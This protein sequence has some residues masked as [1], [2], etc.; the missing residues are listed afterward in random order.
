M[1]TAG[2]VELGQRFSALEQGPPSQGVPAPMHSRTQVPVPLQVARSPVVLPQSVPAMVP[3][4]MQDPMNATEAMH[5]GKAPA[6]IDIGPPPHVPP[7]NTP[8]TR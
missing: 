5:C 4:S 3:V 6:H 1:Q 8:V 7:E 2:C